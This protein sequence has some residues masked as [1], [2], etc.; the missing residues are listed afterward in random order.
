MEAI[1]LGT[2][3]LKLM[4]LAYFVDNQAD[5]SI[6]SLDG[7]IGQLSIEL[8]P[9][10][11]TATKNLAEFNGLQGEFIEDPSELIGK[12]VDFMIKID[13]AVFPGNQYKDV[14]VEYEVRNHKGDL[15][16]FRSNTVYGTK[17]NPKFRYSFHHFFENVDQKL[18]E[19]LL[20]QEIEFKLFGIEE[21]LNRGKEMKEMGQEFI[22]TRRTSKSKFYLIFY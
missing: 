13:N 4:A 15:E 17:C 9:T 22:R 21:N 2:G 12:R 18:L 14:F 1:C 19:Y 16:K 5:I 6:M 10:D 11:I 7:S 3:Y 20:N 8:I